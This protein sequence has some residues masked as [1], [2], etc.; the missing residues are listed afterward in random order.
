MI[1]PVKSLQHDAG[2]LMVCHAAKREDWISDSI[3]AIVAGSQVEWTPEEWR[4]VESR[5]QQITNASAAQP[6]NAQT[7]LQLA[8]AATARSWFRLRM[9]FTSSVPRT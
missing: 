7:Q 8:V 9:S 6:A 5:L 4:V 2:H 1:A 3:F